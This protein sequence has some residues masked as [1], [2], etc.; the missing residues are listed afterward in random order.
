MMTVGQLKQLL[1]DTP[2]DFELYYVD[3][4]YGYPELVQG[5]T[6]TT[7]ASYQDMVSFQKRSV[8]FR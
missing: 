5:C 2:D 1:A 4:L 8:T 7:D 6:V 3:K